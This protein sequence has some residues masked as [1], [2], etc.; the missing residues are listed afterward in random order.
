MFALEGLDWI[1]TETGLVKDLPVVF[2]LDWPS[3]GLWVKLCERSAFWTK[4]TANNFFTQQSKF[5]LI[6][7][8][9]DRVQSESLL[10]PPRLGGVEFRTN[11][12]QIQSAYVH[13]GGLAIQA[14]SKSSPSP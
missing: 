6:A 3:T 13:T 7:F 1:L 5:S 12:D 4:H 10:N 9:L 14:Q 2:T 8:T 11:P